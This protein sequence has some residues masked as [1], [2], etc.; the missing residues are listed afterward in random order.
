ML[1][2][3]ISCKSKYLVNSAD[4]KP[5]GRVVECAKCGNQWYQGLILNENDTITDESII[6]QP[7]IISRNNN[8]LKPTTPNLPSTYVKETKVSI[9]NSFLVIL[10]IVI[11]LVGFWGI[12]KLDINSFVLLEFYIDEF[13]F[14]LRLIFNDIVKIIHQ[15]F[16]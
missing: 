10:F 15:I 11:L 5:E 3:C 14:N 6:S 7:S 13:T 8:N 16:N 1:I 2:S 4:L 12:K 9:T